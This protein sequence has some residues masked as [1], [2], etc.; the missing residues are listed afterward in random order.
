MPHNRADVLLNRDSERRTTMPNAFHVLLLGHLPHLRR[1]ALALTRSSNDA[2]ELVQETAFKA[3]RAEKHFAAGTNFRAWCFAIM[4]NT[5][6]TEA[7]RR[8]R[9]CVP[10]TDVSD[11][12]IARDPDQE[13]RVLTSETLSRVASLPDRERGI[14]MAVAHD[15]LPYE[16]VAARFRC[17]LGTVK[18]RVSRVR[19]KLQAQMSGVEN[20]RRPVRAPKRASDNREPR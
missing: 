7:L 15:G 18:S 1:Y 2:D 20:S 10:I 5:Y 13:W 14:L 6:L 3:L 8:Q 19:A 12:L 17:N 4:R 11:G 16:R 9:T